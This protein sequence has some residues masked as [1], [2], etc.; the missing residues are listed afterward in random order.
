MLQITIPAF[1]YFD[2]IREEF[3]DVKKDTT[4]QLEHS[5]KSIAKWEAKWK[6][7]FIGN[8]RTPPKSR[9]ELI[10][11]I[12]CMTLTQNVDPV[13]YVGI[14][15]S[16]LQA[17]TEYIEDPMTA[18]W[19]SEDSKK[20]PNSEIITAEIVY[21]WM[22]SLNIPLECEKWHLNRLITLIRVCSI[23]N[24]PPKKMNPKQALSKRRALNAA[25]NK[26]FGSHK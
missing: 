1:S 10:D 11:Y 15:N 14:T 26:R 22:I 8:S 2:E 21:Y 18:T 5:L 24:Q 13:V 23:K 17:V 19:F 20:K 6:K 3:I 16:I 7:P 9:E 12:R 4:L 25:R